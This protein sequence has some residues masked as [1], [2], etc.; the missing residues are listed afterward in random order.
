MTPVDRGPARNG[1]DLRARGAGAGL[2]QRGGARRRSPGPTA[3]L[4]AGRD[5]RDHRCRQRASIRVAGKVR[6]RT[7]RD[8]APIATS[9]S[10]VFRE[11]PFATDRRS[12]SGACACGATRSASVQAE[13]SASSAIRLLR[14]RVFDAAADADVRP[15]GAASP[16]STIGSSALDSSRCAARHARLRQP[17]RSMRP[18]LRER[19]ADSARHRRQTQLRQTFSLGIVPSLLKPLARKRRRISARHARIKRNRQLD[20]TRRLCKP[21]SQCRSDWLKRPRCR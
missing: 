8:R 13:R 21:C 6:L 16:L 9:P 17:A 15:V 5:R 20:T 4:D 12:G 19:P 2:C 14:R 1:L 11:T 18:L 10:S 3:T 7:R